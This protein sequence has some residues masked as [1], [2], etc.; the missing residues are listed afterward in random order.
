[1][2]EMCRRENR[3]IKKLFLM[4]LFVNID[5]CVNHYSFAIVRFFWTR[6]GPKEIAGNLESL[7]LDALA[8]IDPPTLILSFL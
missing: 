8:A 6:S 5:A 2:K 1:M 4:G 3:E 7:N